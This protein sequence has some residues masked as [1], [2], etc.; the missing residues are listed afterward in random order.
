MRGGSLGAAGL[1]TAMAP[2]PVRAAQPRTPDLI[3]VNANVY[4]V[5][6][7]MPQAQAFAIKDGRFMA[8]G[9]NADIKALA[10]TATQTVDAQGMT[11]IPGFIDCH[12][13]AP[14]TRLL[15][16]VIVGNPYEVEFVTIDGIVDK[17]K[18]DNSLTTP[19]SRMAASSMCMISTRSR[20][21]I[22]LW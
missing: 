10:G 14:G 18:K 6:D 15:N 12:N 21:T 8:V 22:R 4:T 13:H 20:S 7:S 1:L 9:T 2:W 5:D 17:L 19:K 16:D 3:V 11:V